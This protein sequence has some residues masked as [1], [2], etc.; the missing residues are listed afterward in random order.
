[1]QDGQINNTQLTLDHTVEN[2][3]AST[4]LKSSV[5]SA[6]EERAAMKSP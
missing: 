1:M 3:R 4:N 2:F 6:R 5:I